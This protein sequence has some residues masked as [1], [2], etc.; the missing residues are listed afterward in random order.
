MLTKDLFDGLFLNFGTG[1]SERH[2]QFMLKGIHRRGDGPSGPSCRIKCALVA[3]QKFKIHLPVDVVTLWGHG[4]ENRYGVIQF[5]QIQIPFDPLR[6]PAA[7]CR[8]VTSL[9]ELRMA[10]R[11]MGQNGHPLIDRAFPAERTRPL[12]ACATA[13]AIS[14]LLDALRDQ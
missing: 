12:S 9:A 8:N 6:N 7:S 4:I 14:H 2:F 13:E 5:R 1:P 11:A 3:A 10:G